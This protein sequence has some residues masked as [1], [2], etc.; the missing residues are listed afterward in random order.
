MQT[1]QQKSSLQEDCT[2][3]I[4]LYEQ[5]AADPI[6]SHVEMLDVAFDKNIPGNK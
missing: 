6:L 3:N 5:T 1:A 4:V 2:G